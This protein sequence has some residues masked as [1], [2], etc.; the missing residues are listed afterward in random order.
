MRASR[1]SVATLAA[2]AAEATSHDLTAMATCGG[3]VADEDAIVGEEEEEEAIPLP[4][5]A[6]VPLLLQGSSSA[7]APLLLF[8]CALVWCVRTESCMLR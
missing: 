2:T 6:V 1:P 7:V 5:P 4:P 3:S 8:I